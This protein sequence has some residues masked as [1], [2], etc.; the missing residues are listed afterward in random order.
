[1]CGTS[2]FSFELNVSSSQV[3]SCNDH[4]LIK[5]YW[6]NHWKRRRFYLLMLEPSSW[7]WS[8]IFGLGI[9]LC[10]PGL[11]VE[12][13]VLGIGLWSMVLVTVLV[14]FLEILILFTSLVCWWYEERHLANFCHAPEKLHLHMGMCHPQI[15]RAW[16]LPVSCSLS[17]SNLCTTELY[18]CVCLRWTLILY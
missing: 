11:G 5:T 16:H 7:S 14:L 17:N 13:C 10:V 1:M 3:N 2:R 18:S 9:E 8:Q 15:G 4:V 6:L 12:L